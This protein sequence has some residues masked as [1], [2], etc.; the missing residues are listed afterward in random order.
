VIYSVWNHADRRYAYYR[1]AE[2]SATVNT[3]SPKHLLGGTHEI[4]L[5][6]EEAAWPLPAD[7]E[8]VGYGREPKGLIASSESVGY[9]GRRGPL[10]FFVAGLVLAKIWD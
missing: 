2:R 1:T 9:A 5:S 6:P 7:A 3:P 10:L 4:G 8:L